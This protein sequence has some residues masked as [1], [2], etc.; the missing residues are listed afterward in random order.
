MPANELDGSPSVVG[1]TNPPT[2]VEPLAK[3]KPR[4]PRG[5]GTGKPKPRPG[6]LLQTRITD[7][8]L[9]AAYNRFK[10]SLRVV[11]PDSDI[12]ATAIQELLEREGFYKLK[13]QPFADPL[14]E[15]HNNNDA[16]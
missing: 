6:V 8:D 16:A 3:R 14:A 10:S 12:V 4:R 1:T 15:E 9:I 13:R 7:A 11:P 5:K 2:E